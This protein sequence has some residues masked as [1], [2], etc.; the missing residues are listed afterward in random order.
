MKK[1]TYKQFYWLNKDSE[2]FLKRGYIDKDSSVEG[3]VKQIAD[4]AERILKKPGFSE[5]FYE[6][7]ANGWISLSSPIWSNFGAGRGLSISCNGS[8]CPDNVS[9]ILTTMAETGKM[10]QNGAGTSGFFGKIRPRGSD[11]STGGKADGPVRFLELIESVTNIITQNNVRR[12]SFAAY[13]PVEHPDIKD[14]LKIRSEGHA[15]QNLSIG[16]TI[17][18]KWMEDMTGGDKEKREIWGQIIKKRFSTGYPYIM[19][20]DT[21]NNGKPKVYKDKDIT[22]YAS[23]LCSETAIPAS[24]DESFVCCLSSVNLLHYDEWKETDLVE[25]L[26]YFLDA[27]ME[28]YIVKT[29]DMPHMERAHR[30]AQRHRALG[31]GVLGWHS[32]LQSKMVA[33]ESLEAKFLNNQIFKLINEKTLAA[34]KQM[35]VEYGEPELLKGYGERN[36]TRI[37]IAP[38]TS[39]SFILGQ[40]SPSIEPLNSNFFTKDLAKGSFPY[41]NPHLKE[42]L[43]EKGEDSDEVWKSIL[44]KGGSV[45]HLKF[46]SQEEKDVFKTFSEIS[47][48]EVVLQAGQRQ[49]H[50]DQGQSLNLM[51]PIEASPKEVS[52]LLIEGWKTGV[53]CFY[54]H[55]GANPAQEL[56]RSIM[57]CKSCE[58]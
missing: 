47:Q 1:R 42:L 12:G 44:V 25:T 34:T 5:K 22:I 36:T 28:D 57:S 32:Y 30:F 40:V 23:N 24:E 10:T 52:N 39:S 43:K 29:K 35:A 48:K 51:I 13:L 54:Y 26:T 3:R 27:V 49:R 16:V 33:F 15:I 31:L 41:K 45:Q 18:D 55:R 19:F 2:T 37:A 14:F 53:K 6:Y 58:A 9:G 50:I 4:E 20:H 7:M 38:T 56:A 46:L 17:T 8:L 21:V 11:I